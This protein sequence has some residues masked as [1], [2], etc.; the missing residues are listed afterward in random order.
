MIIEFSGWMVYLVGA[1][2]VVETISIFAHVFE[3][4]ER[5]REGK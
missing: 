5:F 4:W 1:M 2:C 3:I